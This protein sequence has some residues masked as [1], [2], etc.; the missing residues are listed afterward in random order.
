MTN[1]T[2]RSS[3][4][5]NERNMAQHRRLMWVALNMPVEC[6]LALERFCQ[7]N[8]RWRGANWEDCLDVLIDSDSHLE[9]TEP[10]WEEFVS[11]TD[12]E[13]DVLLRLIGPIS[14]TLFYANG[15]PPTLDD[16]VTVMERHG[17]G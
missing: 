13:D 4:D 6:K 17:H 11:I 2:L 10:L 16:V 7:A 5:F 3:G 1:D 8:Y 12:N 14:V 9:L 15:E